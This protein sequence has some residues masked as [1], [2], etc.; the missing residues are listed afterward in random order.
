VFSRNGKGPPP[1][2]NDTR[3]YPPA[4]VCPWRPAGEA[5]GVGDPAVVETPPPPLSPCGCTWCVVRVE[6]AA[7]VVLVVRCGVWWRVVCGAWCVRGR[8]HSCRPQSIQCALAVHA[9]ALL[10]ALGPGH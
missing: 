1:P 2:R 10:S 7:R 4:Y 5:R 8:A 3:T 9:H 6:L